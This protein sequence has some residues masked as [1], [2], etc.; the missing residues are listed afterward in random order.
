MGA[1]VGRSAIW[2]L[3][4][5]AAV[6]L[7]RQTALPETG[8]ALFWP[9]AGVAALWIQR[10]PGRLLVVNT[11]TLFVTTVVVNAASGV[12]WVPALVFGLAN[13]TV[14]CTVRRVLAW[15][16]PS[17][18]TATARSQRAEAMGSIH[19]VVALAQASVAAGLTSAPFGM[20][21]GFLITDQ[22]TAVGVF[23]W[24]L[25]NT[26]GVFVVAGVVLA[27]IAA[28]HA[29]RPG[30]S[31]SSVVTNEDRPNGTIDLATTVVLAAATLWVVFASNHGL[32]L[33]FVLVAVGAFVGFRF[34][35]VIA[36]VLTTAAG[37]FA[38]LASL[39]GTGPFGTIQDPLVRSLVVQAYV[40][41]QAVISLTLSWAVRERHDVTL[42][43]SEARRQADER[44]QLLDAVTNRLEHG[45]AVIDAA[46]HILVQN[47][48]AVRLVPSPQGRITPDDHPSAYGV[49][50]AD[51]GPMT[52]ETM[53][54]SVA[55]ATGESVTAEL[56]VRRDG[57]AD[58][59]VAVRADPLDLDGDPTRRLAVV[60]LRDDTAYRRQVDE[61]E[62]FSAAVAHDLRNPLAAMQSWVEVLTE[63]LTEQATLDDGAREAI[64]RIAATGERMSTLIDDLLA[65]ARAGSAPLDVRQVDLD[66]VV[67]E[68]AQ[69]IVAA[70]DRGALVRAN[71]LGTVAG[72]PTLLRQVLAN[73]IG[74]AV[75]Y[76]A[77]DVVPVIGV[78]AEHSPDG[79]VVRVTDNGI[80]V[81]EHLQATVFE[82]FAR[83]SGTSSGRT[84]SG[85]GLA[86]CARAVQRHDGTIQLTSGPGGTGSTVTM[87]FPARTGQDLI[88][89]A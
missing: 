53:P 58:S 30:A 48:A 88:A 84:G 1:L 15:A 18:R 40:L 51:G 56:V 71:G 60:S 42:E 13:V 26:T 22:A 70:T 32:P 17:L 78:Q 2:A 67:D 35:P 43:L 55:L 47:P 61:L 25:R 27:V 83:V 10:S 62:T 85:L 86:L 79:V 74:N 80:G 4:Y 66:D 5:A 54:H 24:V 50:R 21:A 36:A 82:P 77:D 73:V 28:R 75:K 34:S 38:V 31:W 29:H 81:P 23:A 3:L 12:A 7:G 68:V 14:G 65:Y 57:A 11:A 19:G 59:Y 44:A 39:N 45:I 6:V 16:L 41:I 89:T 64:G 63:H 20:L 52:P 49:H 9:A 46:G 72:D 8:L 69:E 87:C 76:T 37:V 33:S